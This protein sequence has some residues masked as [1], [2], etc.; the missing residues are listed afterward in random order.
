M[1]KYRLTPAAKKDLIAIWHYTVKVWGIEK[2][3]QYSKTILI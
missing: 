3:R 2:A 1:I